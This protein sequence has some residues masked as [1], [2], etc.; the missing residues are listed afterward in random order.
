MGALCGREAQPPLE[1]GAEPL[2]SGTP[3]RQQSRRMSQHELTDLDVM[4][5][6]DVTR[7]VS[8]GGRVRS[9]LNKVRVS[10][11]LESWL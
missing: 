6:E 2:E 9:S 10:P 4:N 1:T 7:L 5:Q 11:P 8:G 3:E